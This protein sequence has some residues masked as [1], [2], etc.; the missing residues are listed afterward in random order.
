M[1]CRDMF[2]RKPCIHTYVNILLLVHT[3]DVVLRRN[4]KSLFMERPTVAAHGDTPPYVPT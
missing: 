4:P 2:A 3:L 1:S